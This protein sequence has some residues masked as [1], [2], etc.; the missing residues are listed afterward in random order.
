[1]EIK[2]LQ[3]ATTQLPLNE[4]NLPV[5]KIDMNFRM[6]ATGEASLSKE[7]AM[8]LKALTGYAGTDFTITSATRGANH[9]LH[10]PN[11]L[12]A[13]GNAID[14][15]IQS[16]DGKAM[17]EFFFTD[18]DYTKLSDAGKD[19]L[20]DNNAELIDERS[21]SGAAH[22]HLEFNTPEFSTVL[23]DG[24]ESSLYNEGATT[25]SEGF[26]IYGVQGTW[27]AN[28]YNQNVDFLNQMKTIAGLEDHVDIGPGSDFFNEFGIATGNITVESKAEG[29][30]ANAKKV[31]ADP[32]DL[33]KYSPTKIDPY[34]R[35]SKQSEDTFMEFLVP[36][37]NLAPGYLP[38]TK[39]GEDLNFERNFNVK[40]K[41]P[42]ASKKSEYEEYMDKQDLTVFT[43]KGIT[44]WPGASK[45]QAAA[46]LQNNYQK[47]LRGIAGGGKAFANVIGQGSA[48][49]YAG[50]PMAV[51]T[52]EFDQVYNNGLNKLLS[53]YDEHL[54]TE[55]P[56]YYTAAQQANTE[57]FLTSWDAF[58]KSLGTANFWSKDFLQGIG[59][60]LG[61]A[62]SGSLAARS[63]FGAKSFDLASSAGR[64]L[65]PRQMA[66]S[67]RKASF[68]TGA[69]TLAA[70]AS[71]AKKR[72]VANFIGAGLVSAAG[73]ATIEAQHI[74]QSSYEAIKD[75]KREGAE[76][77]QGMDDKEM[78]ELAASYS[79][80]AWFANIAIV[81][82][83]NMLMF[84]HLFGSGVSNL[85]SKISKNAIKKG[86]K[87]SLEFNYKK[88]PQW[89]VRQGKR[90]QSPIA[91]GFE[92]WSQYALELGGKDYFG[93]THNPLLD[94]EVKAV[95]GMG[96]MLN[97][98]ARGFVKTPQT[99]EG[100][101]G[102]FLG[103]L[104]GSLGGAYAGTRGESARQQ[105]KQKVKQAEKL[106]ES[107]NILN[108]ND[109]LY[110]IMRAMSELK[111]LDKIQLDSISSKD[112]FTASTAEVRKAFEI[113]DLFYETGQVD[114]L[115]DI[116]NDAGKLSK[117]EFDAEFEIDSE[118]NVNPLKEIERIKG[119][120]RSYEL[121]KD[122]D[123]LIQRAVDAALIALQNDDQ[124]E[125]KV[126]AMKRELRYATFMAQELDKKSIDILSE[127]GL[128]SGSSLSLHFLKEMDLTNKEET[129]DAKTKTDAQFE[130]M[131]KKP[132]APGKAQQAY[133][134][135]LLNQYVYLNTLRQSY[136]KL[137]KN[138]YDAPFANVN[139]E[140]AER[141][142]KE[143]EAKRENQKENDKITA[144][145]EFEKQKKAEEE[146]A[147]EARQQS[148]P[149]T[150]PK[151]FQQT[152][153]TAPEG[154]T[155]EGEE[156]PSTNLD[157]DGNQ[158]SEELI[159][160]EEELAEEEKN[161]KNLRDKKGNVPNKNKNLF[162]KLS[163]KINNLKEKINRIVVSGGTNFGNLVIQFVKDGKFGNKVINFTIS[164]L[165]L[166]G[167]Y[168]DS[169]IKEGIEKGW[170]VEKVMKRINLFVALN[171]DRLESMQGVEEEGN[172]E[173]TMDSAQEAAIRAYID[174]QLG[175]IQEYKNN[176]QPFN[177]WRKSKKKSAPTAT[178]TTPTTPTTPVAPVGQTDDETIKTVQK[179]NTENLEVP[180][181][182]NVDVENNENASTAQD[183][184]KAVGDI[185]YLGSIMSLGYK[186]VNNT[187][188][189]T[190]A[191]VD[192]QTTNI[193]ENPDIATMAGAVIEWSIDMAELE[194]RAGG[195]LMQESKRISKEAV[196]K[197]KNKQ[198][199]SQ[200][201]L[202][203]LP[204]IGV[205]TKDGKTIRGYVH[206][207]AYVDTNI[208]P[209]SREIEKKI[210][211]GLRKS[212]Y[213]T[214]NEGK[215]ASSVIT[216]MSI[217]HLNFDPTFKSKNNISLVVNG[218]RPGTKQP[219]LIFNDGYNYVDENG[220][221]STDIFTTANPKNKGAIYFKLTAANQEQFPARAFIE[222]LHRE[223]AEVLL[224]IYAGVASRQVS[225]KTKVSKEFI[226]SLPDKGVMKFYKQY[227]TEMSQNSKASKR[228]KF[229]DMLNMLI[230]D[231]T[232]GLEIVFTPVSKG[233]VLKLGS[234]SYTLA[235]LESKKEEIID[236]FVENK[237]Y[238][239][240][241]GR[242]N[243]NN[244][245]KYNEFLIKSKIL[246]TNIF[247]NQNT[248]G[249]FI[250]PTLRFGALIKTKPKA[251]PVKTTPQAPKAK[252]TFSKFTRAQV[253]EEEASQLKKQVAAD[254]NPID[255]VKI[256]KEETAESAQIAI[257]F[258]NSEKEEKKV[259]KFMFGGVSVEKAEDEVAPEDIPVAET[260]PKESVA[261]ETAPSEKESKKP[262]KPI[263]KNNIT[264]GELKIKPK[265][266]M[267]PTSR[268]VKDK[269]KND[270]EINYLGNLR[271]A[272]NQIEKF[273]DKIILEGKEDFGTTQIDDIRKLATEKKY[274]GLLSLFEKLDN[275]FKLKKDYE[276][277][278]SSLKTE[279]DNLEDDCSPF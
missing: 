210:V 223:T 207:A 128:Q 1:M 42:F 79:D 161:S 233:T 243:V 240:L 235:E 91:E 208:K 192:M 261:P 60:L 211:R 267:S 92:E 249:S 25:K 51:I 136:N 54:L 4:Y 242:T 117:E 133:L 271:D 83:S 126:K 21:R 39:P 90:L 49:V 86:V 96:G 16:T 59:F 14:F 220:V 18:S 53:T 266:N 76:M 247:A 9:P 245:F 125:E 244:D 265:V 104:L 85:G 37:T 113:I 33:K 180:T 273:I 171:R 166:F 278:L 74:F 158:K 100:L 63:G 24:V 67:F 137:I 157:E 182:S 214:L 256:R 6:G 228:V 146:A 75:G 65:F 202:D 72:Q 252:H 205:S 230:Y 239:V 15:G 167:N 275:E 66:N 47:W 150:A 102:I 149:E 264:F 187:G 229:T 22:F 7:A 232:K 200:Q 201:D 238:N 70:A 28:E 246:Y 191:G 120:I 45:T 10:N 82:S 279:K 52:G 236:W 71:Y 5:P 173:I 274:T 20:I 262:N 185:T 121:L 263:N 199:L 8:G 11:S 119:A 129:L 55:F 164:D 93:Y 195:K 218:G 94:T 84:R 12:H 103:A 36:N 175:N 172:P 41:L 145:E 258:K 224:A 154:F 270:R 179:A 170:S 40:V 276:I 204:I 216:E 131:L 130:E 69:S 144:A 162:K 123:P 181:N 98:M 213:N 44:D 163:K 189:Y 234:Q 169:V 156:Q 268:I 87:R 73:E 122:S 260:G 135:E 107:Y 118:A 221:A 109:D 140:F 165:N 30:I 153:E 209:K 142:S 272:E 250:Q 2:N 193:L 277:L 124:A 17:M 160:L 248:S 46:D 197:V 147:E 29:L 168:V 225:L 26:P 183:D 68:K 101:Q 132:D 110:K 80:V 269:S 23:E 184:G 64:R 77:Y 177:V 62:K 99:K 134:A 50:L 159:K 106:V 61:A 19:Y 38:D 194:R 253:S 111:N 95:E 89:F 88:L 138:I 206:T 227:L 151:G 48:L 254:K 81:G 27:K 127:I 115:N 57:G 116:I 97:S 190:V 35:Y 212:I 58:G 186:S 139:K 257:N 105:H 155:K 231:K 215:K 176:R 255:G 56:H 178:P 3:P 174:A 226:K 78:R 222:N 251:A 259:N 203:N 31:E 32:E 13:E 141:N 34:T 143:A 217:G 114:I 152:T 108:K 241:K 196:E 43:D 198:P 219:F 237:R 188:G 112:L 148:K